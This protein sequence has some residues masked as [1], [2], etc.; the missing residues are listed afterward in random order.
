MT[1]SASWNDPTPQAPS[2]WREW[3]PPLSLLEAASGD[4]G[5][6]AELIDAFHT[7]TDD[8]IREMRA[9]L[10][11]TEF[12]RIG[13]EA[14]SIKGGARQLGADALADACQ[15]LGTLSEVQEAAPVVAALSRVLELYDEILRAM[16]AYSDSRSLNLSVTSLK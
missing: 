1:S 10:A 9:A 4:E 13:S 7:D 3:S 8:R 6:I 5:L 16:A 15:D 12:S 14:H 11:I 2:T